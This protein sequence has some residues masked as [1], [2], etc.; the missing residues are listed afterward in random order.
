ML[1]LL[2]PFCCLFL[3]NSYQN[4]QNYFLL[5][6]LYS[7]MRSLMCQYSEPSL[8]FNHCKESLILM[9][10]S[11]S[12]LTIQI[13][14]HWLFWSFDY[15]LFF[16]P[17]SRCRKGKSWLSCHGSNI[18]KK[19]KKTPQLCNRVMNATLVGICK[20]RRTTYQDVFLLLSLGY[21]LKSLAS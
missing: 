14:S 16:F 18:K 8:L 7:H 10:L 13:Q 19:K 20:T 15:V 3:C 21:S 12:P 2:L 9:N 11:S 6:N 17:W 5:P 1:K 4:V